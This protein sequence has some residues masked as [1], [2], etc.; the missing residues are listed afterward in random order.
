MRK[1]SIILTLVSGLN[2]FAID[3]IDIVREEIWSK[4]EVQSPQSQLVIQLGDNW[5]EEIDYAV[6]VMEEH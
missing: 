2:V 6:S 5:S 1:L 4:F 3:T